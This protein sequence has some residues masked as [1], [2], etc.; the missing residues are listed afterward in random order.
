VL[1]KGARAVKAKAAKVVEHRQVQTVPHHQQ[2][3]EKGVRLRR[4][5]PVS[6]VLFMQP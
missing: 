2:Q 3:Q 4:S 1:E 5:W 6:T